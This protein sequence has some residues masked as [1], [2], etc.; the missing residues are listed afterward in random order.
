MPSRAHIIAARRMARNAANKQRCRAY[1][2]SAK[3]NINKRPH[4]A[5]AQHG[6]LARRPLMTWRGW[7]RSA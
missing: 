2:L 7:Q 3:L 4:G 5:M 1:A 6:A